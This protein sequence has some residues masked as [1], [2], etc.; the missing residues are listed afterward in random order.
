MLLTGISLCYLGGFKI[1]YWFIFLIECEGPRWQLHV[2]GCEPT[3]VGGKK[4]GAV[5]DGFLKIYVLQKLGSIGKLG[6]LYS[7]V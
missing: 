6:Q 3:G 4:H 7:C 2:L 5:D 1:I